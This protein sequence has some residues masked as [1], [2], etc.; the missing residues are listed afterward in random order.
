MQA[1]PCADFPPVP[2]PLA[3]S[4]AEG[5]ILLAVMGYPELM[6]WG[7]F[8]AL[9]DCPTAVQQLAYTVGKTIQFGFPVVWV[10]GICRERIRSFWGQGR[11]GL[12]EGL[13][14][15]LLAALTIL[16]AYRYW[17]APTGFFQ[18][19]GQALQKKTGR[20]GPQQ[21][22]PICRLGLFLR[23]GTL[24]FGRVLLAGICLRPITPSSPC[25]Q[26]FGQFE[27]RL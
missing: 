13:A 17:L 25:G 19:A 8:L 11:R 16:I 4:K 26:G 2:N 7:Y 15:G 24:F 10:L 1:N 6:T 23:P 9:S 18:Q 14:F 22:R 27:H 21:P 3:P 12:A 20:H 5:W